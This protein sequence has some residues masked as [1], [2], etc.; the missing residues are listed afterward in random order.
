MESEQTSKKQMTLLPETK[1]ER[2]RTRAP[3][4]DEGKD[5]KGMAAIPAPG[6]E[7]EGETSRRR[8]RGTENPSGKLDRRRLEDRAKRRPANRHISRGEGI[9]PLGPAA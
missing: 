5:L 6:V 1:Q 7:A 3:G 4:P 8:N 2:E 9:H